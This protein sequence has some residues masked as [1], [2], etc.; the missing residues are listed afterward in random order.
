M[1]AQ[2][3]RRGKV[4]GLTVNQSTV[5][6]IPTAP[7]SECRTVSAV[8]GDVPDG[9]RTPV[10]WPERQPNAAA[11][12]IRVSSPTGRGGRPKPCTVPVR[13]RGDPLSERR[14]PTIENAAD[15]VTHPTKGGAHGLLPSLHLIP[16]PP[17]QTPLHIR[18]LPLAHLRN[19]QR[20]HR[21]RHRHLLEPNTPHLGQPRRIHQRR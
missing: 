17:R 10:K 5:G 11:L 3:S 16:H 14:R 4:P 7:T 2:G 20:H 18:T 21:R 6:S 1:P 9:S 13:I 15:Q 12:T 19:M 8:P